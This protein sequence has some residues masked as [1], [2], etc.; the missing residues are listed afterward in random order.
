M[1]DDDA[2]T[3]LPRISDD[4]D[5]IVAKLEADRAALVDRDAAA[6]AETRPLAL[7][8][9]LG[10]A[11]A[12]A[13]LGEVNA[14]RIALARHLD[15]LQGAIEDARARLEATRDAEAGASRA[16]RLAEASAIARAIL[17]VDASIDDRL[18]RLRADFAERQRLI[19]SLKPLGQLDVSRTNKLRNQ[20]MMLAGMSAAGLGDFLP[21]ARIASHHWQ[22]ISTWDGKILALL[23]P[24]VPAEP[25]PTEAEA[26]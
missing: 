19:L 3:D 18:A 6:L 23:L 1:S 16:Q 26:A 24:P 25:A 7:S 2:I 20:T 22:T 5:G 9:A 8:A 21:I 15:N 14:E 17:A 10:D 13:R 12:T 11:A 4:W